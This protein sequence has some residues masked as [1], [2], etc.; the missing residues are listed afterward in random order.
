M[1]NLI[2]EKLDQRVVEDAVKAATA[3]WQGVS[4]ID[5]VVAESTL[6]PDDYTG[7]DIIL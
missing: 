6:V 5:F 3:R 7:K 1:L 2:Y 4:L